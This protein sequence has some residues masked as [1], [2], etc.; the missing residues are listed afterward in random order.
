ML[1]DN[2]FRLTVKN[3]SFENAD[4][5]VKILLQY[6]DEGK[7]SVKFLRIRKGDHSV[8]CAFVV[9]L[10]GHMMN[11]SAI[12]QLYLKDKKLDKMN[13]KIKELE[14]HNKELE[15]KISRND[16][17]IKAVYTI[18]D[19]A[20]EPQKQTPYLITTVEVKPYEVTIQHHEI[21]VVIPKYNKDDI[22]YDP[23]AEREKER[24]SLGKI[25][26]KICSECGTRN[27]LDAIYCKHCSTKFE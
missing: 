7:I 3:L 26:Y 23:L 17:N 24:K 12:I 16:K 19:S 20:I 9:H 18:L 15:E 25:N 4:D 14:N 6:I 11:V 8:L 22:D 1:K 10:F 5:L 2:E 21:K 27:D 13:D